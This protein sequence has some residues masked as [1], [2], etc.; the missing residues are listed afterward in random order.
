MAQA[1]SCWSGQERDFAYARHTKN[2]TKSGPRYL[3]GNPEIFHHQI[4]PTETEHRYL[5]SLARGNPQ[6]RTGALAQSLQILFQ[7]LIE[8]IKIIRLFYNY[9]RFFSF[10]DGRAMGGFK[11]G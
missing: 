4:P 3:L 9:S 7:N 1:I 5:P 2:P 8:G 11:L 10:T 6:V